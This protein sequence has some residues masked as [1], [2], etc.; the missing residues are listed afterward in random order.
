MIRANA[1]SKQGYGFLFDKDKAHTVQTTRDATT[2]IPLNEWHH[3]AI[4]FDHSTGELKYYMDGELKA[5]T[6]SAWDGWGDAST[7][8]KAGVGDGKFSMNGGYDEVYIYDEVRTQEQIAALMVPAPLDPPTPALLTISIGADTVTVGTTNL[9][10]RAGVT[11]TLQATTDLS[12][13]SWSDVSAVTGVTETNWVF[14]VTNRNFY[15]IES[16]D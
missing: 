14:S 15:R 13:D 10:A 16:T 2:A 6:T 8:T 12:G 3:L 4:T 11:N 1:T 5:S 9:T 7:L